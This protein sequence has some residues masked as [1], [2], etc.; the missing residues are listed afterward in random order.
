MANIKLVGNSWEAEGIFDK[1]QN[2]TQKAINAEI[3]EVAQNNSDLVILRNTQPTET[4]NKIWIKEGVSYQIPVMADLVSN[5]ITNNSSV[6]GTNVTGALNTLGSNVS[7]LQ[8]SLNSI[9]AEV[10]DDSPA[11]VNGV[12]FRYRIRHNILYFSIFGIPTASDMLQF[13]IPRHLATGIYLSVPQWGD[14]SNI[15]QVFGDAGWTELRVRNFNIPNKAIN[16]SGVAP[17]VI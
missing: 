15:M 1:T 13:P 17:L 10:T 2:K 8:G 11:A 5:N 6:S 9:N 16:V 7:S 3:A 12:Y 14:T 4:G